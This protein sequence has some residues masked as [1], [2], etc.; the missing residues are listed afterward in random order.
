MPL[1][2][3]REVQSQ[4]KKN[5]TPGSLG[6]HGDIYQY[7]TLLQTNALWLQHATPS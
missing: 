5:E 3:R 1:D 2:V 6:E 7:V 4:I